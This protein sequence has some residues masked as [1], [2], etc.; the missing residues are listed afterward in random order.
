MRAPSVPSPARRR[1]AHRSTA[2]S[3]FAALGIGALVALGALPTTPA[4]A[5]AAS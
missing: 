4:T 1:R 2:A 5:A 3:L